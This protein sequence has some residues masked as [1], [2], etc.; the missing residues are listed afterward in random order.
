MGV[1]TGFALYLNTMMTNFLIV[2]ASYTLSTQLP[3]NNNLV[4]AFETAMPV[5][6]LGWHITTLPLR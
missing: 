2:N 5:N 4:N 1:A 3:L 6:K